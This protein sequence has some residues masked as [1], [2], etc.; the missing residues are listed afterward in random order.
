MFCLQFSLSSWLQWRVSKLR[1]VASIGN[2]CLSP[3]L[4]SSLFSFMST[5]PLFHICFSS[6]K[7]SFDIINYWLGGRK[8]LLYFFPDFWGS[9]ER[10]L[11]KKKWENTHF[12]LEPRGLPL[13]LSSARYVTLGK[14][15]GKPICASVSLS[16]IL[17]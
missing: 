15:L 2:F 11:K 14:L 9:R 6:L 5:S 3:L 12:K 10:R 7:H 1:I 8:L 17:G 13:N 4:L 16:A